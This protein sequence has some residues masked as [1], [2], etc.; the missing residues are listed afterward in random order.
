[1][2][3]TAVVSPLET[4]FAIPSF[5]K[6]FFISFTLHLQDCRSKRSEK[7]K[8]LAMFS[9]HS[10]VSKAIQG[11]GNLPGKF[12]KPKITH[13]RAGEHVV[14]KAN[15]QEIMFPMR[16]FLSRLVHNFSSTV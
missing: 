5:V 12:Y 1:M 7:T 15:V 2:V 16:F 9:Y 14:F 13:A 8:N 10:F 3:Q 6:R 4:F 11:L